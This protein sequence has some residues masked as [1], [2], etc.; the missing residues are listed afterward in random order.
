MFTLVL[1]ARLR[2]F[3]VA[4][5]A[6][7]GGIRTRRPCNTTRQHGKEV[8]QLCSMGLKVLASVGVCR[9]GMPWNLPDAELQSGSYARRF[10]T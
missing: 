7:R 9:L 6:R 10:R 1:V 2:R 8:G 3:A 5:S 4:Y